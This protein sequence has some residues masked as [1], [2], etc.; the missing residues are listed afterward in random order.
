M[1]VFVGLIFN[2]LE[3]GLI[4]GIMAMGVYIT[5][6]IL[7]FP[8]LSVDGTFPMGACVTGALIAGGVNPWVACLAAFIAGAAAGCVTGLLHVKL[9]ITDL[10]SGI[11]VMT[12]LWSVNLV[13]TRGSAVLPFY[14]KPTVFTS[15][16]IASLLPQS[17][18]N[19]RVALIALLVVV[20]VKVLLDTYLNTKSGLLLRASGNNPQYVISLGK[21]PGR[22]KIAGLAIGNGCTA[23]S[24]SILAQQTETA[25]IYGG[26]GMVVMALASVIIGTSLLGKIKFIRPT[27]MVVIGAILYKTCLVAAMQLG[28][29]TNYLK[30]LMAALFTFALVGNRAFSGRRKHPHVVNPTQI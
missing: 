9:H 23:L 6:R 5:Y 30:L 12:G 24:G 16:P 20:L 15:G 8:D 29:P 3:E 18:Q 13:I 11:L 21:D 7:G 22:M 2:V 27:A 10:L 25:N 28:L 1:D 14:N 4:Y 26:T 17:L 19:Y